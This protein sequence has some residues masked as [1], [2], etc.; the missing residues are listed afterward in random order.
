MNRLFIL[1]FF[2]LPI[3]SAAPAY[4]DCKAEIARFQKLLDSDVRVG[5]VARSVYD[6]A[7][8]DL[9]AAGKFCASGQDGAA[10]AAVRTTR[11]RY[12][13]PPN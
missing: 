8:A 9:A 5:H 11:G 1:P 12:G 4:A 7:T 10:S 2:L 6:R 3:I 13:Y